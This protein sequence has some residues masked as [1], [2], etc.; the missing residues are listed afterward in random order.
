LR[1]I[2]RVTAWLSGGNALVSINSCCVYIG[3]G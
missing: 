2:P 1:L 3:P